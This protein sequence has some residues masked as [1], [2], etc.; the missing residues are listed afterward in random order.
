FIF[1]FN[2]LILKIFFIYWYDWP[3]ACSVISVNTFSVTIDDLTNFTV[4][5]QVPTHQSVSRLIGS[6]EE[7]RRP[8]K[9]HGREWTLSLLTLISIRPC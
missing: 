5:N 7:G 3:N 9:H 4:G 1:L 2:L 6:V 8:S